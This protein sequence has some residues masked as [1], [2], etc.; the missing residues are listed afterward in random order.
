MQLQYNINGLEVEAAIEYINNRLNIQNI[1]SALVLGTGLGNSI[2]SFTIEDEIP[3]SD[4]PF[5]P[6]S[7]VQSHTGKLILASVGPTK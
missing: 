1:S 2:E 4:I 5:A 7:T 6:I 3:Y